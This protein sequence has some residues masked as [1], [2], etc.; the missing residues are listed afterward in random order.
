MSVFKTEQDEFWAGKFGDDYERR[1][2][3]KN[4]IASNLALF[5]RILR[6][7]QKVKTV[8]EF[9]ANI[10]L[11]LKAI[12]KLLPDAKLDAVEIPYRGNSGKLY[13]RGFAG[14]V[15]DQFPNLRLLDYGFVY[16]CDS[17]FPQ[18]DCTWF[19]VEKPM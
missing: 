13:K 15:L 3:D 8:I 18:D 1:N 19:L 14:E 12:Q 9:G 5:S 10:G 2:R 16:R 6:Q 4:W 17:N 7:T 11:N